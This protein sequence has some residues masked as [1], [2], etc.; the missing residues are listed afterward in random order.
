MISSL[1]HLV[2]GILGGNADVI[3]KADV[4]EAGKMD[5]RK[6]LSEFDKGQIV[7]AA[8]PGQSIS[9]TAALQTQVVSGCRKWRC[10]N[11]QFSS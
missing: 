1:W 6:E 4:L 3:L 7:M 9:K 5:K 8:Q 2:V 10:Q 11:T